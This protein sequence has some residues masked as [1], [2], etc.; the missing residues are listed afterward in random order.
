MVGPARR[1]TP[2]PQLV[3]TGDGPQI[4]QNLPID[5][6]EMVVGRR[7]ASDLVLMDPH[8]SSA[9]ARLRRA[10]G[11]VLIEDLGSTNGTFVNDEPLVGSQ[12]LRHGDTVRFGT[13]EARFEDRGSMLGTDDATEVIEMPVEEYL[14]KPLLSPRQTE[15]L[16]YLK[17]GL[18]NPQIAERL[19]VTERTVKAHCQEVYDRLGVPNRTAA[20]DAAHRLGLPEEE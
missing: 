11:A 9:H 4:G 7:E 18:T 1:L 10:K 2:Q 8:V 6:D 13:V 12:A 16:A 15:V 19:G 14:T 3:V 20:V 5:G 17:Q